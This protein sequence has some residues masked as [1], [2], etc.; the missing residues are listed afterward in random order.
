MS[1][2]ESRKRAYIELVFAASL[3]GFGFVALRWTLLG[4]GPL[5]T[6]ALR[7][8]LSF[9]F[10]FLP[11]LVYVP[12]RRRFNSRDLRLGI[13]P[14]FWLGVCLLFQTYGLQY[15]SV[16]KSGFITCLYVVFVPIFARIFYH[17]RITVQH[18]LWVAIA[19]IG[20]ALMCNLDFQQF[21]L[22]DGLT[23]ACA[24]ACAF[25]ILEV[26]R[27]SPRAHSAYTFT[28]G[29]CGAA[30][31]FPLLAAIALE[32]PPSFPLAAVPFAGLFSLI[33]GSSLLAFGIQARTQRFL[34]AP[35]VSLLFLLESPFAAFFG[36]VILGESLSF[37]QA[38]GCLLI[39][40]AAV[41]TIRADRPAAA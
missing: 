21:N 1:T 34:S 26:G 38:M 36:Y 39:L 10:G 5:W 32:A 4:M 9:G 31:V 8:L 25:Q 7:L 16:A 37:L 28:I 24:V 17:H 29:Q 22:G 2:S 15:T 14:G 3:W 40:L 30:G 11:I 19:L 33:F 13:V 23:L 6:N 41:G 35:V 20:A 18:F 12:W 27:Y